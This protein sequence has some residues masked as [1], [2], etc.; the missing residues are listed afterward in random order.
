MTKPLLRSAYIPHKRVTFDGTLLDPKTGELVK[1]PTRTKQSFVAECDINTILK[2]Y[3]ATGQLKHIRANAALHRYE[4]LP[5]DLDF[6]TALNIVKDGETAFASL[7]SKVRDRFG[8]D[9]AN[10]LEFMA[11]PENSQEAVKLGLATAKPTPAPEQPQ[12]PNDAPAS[13]SAPNGS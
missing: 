6:Q 9:P 8:N 11:N 1:P 12:A 4:D 10:F 5:D 7:P 2:Q 3:S 13:P